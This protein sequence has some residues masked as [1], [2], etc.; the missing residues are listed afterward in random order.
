ME[1]LVPS[2]GSG[3][4]HQKHGEKIRLLEGGTVAE[5]VGDHDGA[6]IYTGQPIPLGSMFQMKLLGKE[7]KSSGSIVSA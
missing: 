7:D 1:K 6:F 5:R 3:A 2:L 4:F